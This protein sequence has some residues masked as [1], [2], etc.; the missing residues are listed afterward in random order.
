MIG[1]ALG[2]H[3]HRARRSL[4]K[5][6]PEMRLEILHQLA[7]GGTGQ[8]HCVRGLGEGP[9]FGDAN[10]GAY[11]EYLIQMRPAWSERWDDY[12]QLVRRFHC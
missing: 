10:E 1:G 8:A 11:G 6:R 4:D 12:T 2:G 3:C 5:L 7:D 9:G